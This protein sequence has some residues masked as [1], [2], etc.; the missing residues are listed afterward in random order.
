MTGKK[1]LEK[2][3]LQRRYTIIPLN[4]ISARTLNDKVV[5]AAKNLV[6]GGYSFIY[7]DISVEITENLIYLSGWRG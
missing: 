5:N 6:R 7:Q 2:G 1:L 3:E 4:K